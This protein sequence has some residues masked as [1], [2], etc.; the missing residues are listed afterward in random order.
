MYFPNS[1][2]FYLLLSF[3]NASLYLEVL[4]CIAAKIETLTVLLFLLLVYAEPR[5][6]V[7]IEQSVMEKFLKV[8]A[9]DVL[10]GYMKFC[11][12]SMILSFLFSCQ[13]MSAIFFFKGNSLYF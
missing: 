12:S 5:G 7:D 8:K 3:V 9:E 13:Q 11:S 6:V 1:Q 4:S 2:C 10:S